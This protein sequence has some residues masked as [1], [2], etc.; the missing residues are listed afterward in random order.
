MLFEA[1]KS[2]AAGLPASTGLRSRDGF[3]SY[4]DTVED[5]EQAAAALLARGV[6]PGDRVALLLPNS[7]A[8]FIATHALFAIG[9][10]AV[11]LSA[12]ANARELAWAADACTIAAIVL[13]PGAEAAADGIDSTG[14]L[15]RILATGDDLFARHA[16]STLPQVSGDAHAV[17]LFSS[18]STGR[19]KV[20]PHTH[21]EMHANG[22]ATAAGLGYTPGDVVL[23]ALPGYH[24]FGFMSAH[25]EAVA[26]GATTL[27]WS[28]PQP[29]VMSRE[30]LLA[31][32]AAEG[33]TVL[34]GV[35][36]LFDA[37][38]GTTS[39]AAPGVL[40]L[41][42]SGGVAL[43]RPSFERFRDRF[44]ILIRQA[45]GSTEAGHMSF[46]RSDDAGTSWNSVGRPVGEVEIRV[47]PHEDAPAGTGELFVRSPSLTRG[48]LG[49]DASA[50][51][52][53]VDGG[54]LT[55]DLGRVD[56]EGKVFITG[57][58]KLIIEVAGQKVDPIEI[59]DILAAHPAVEEAV[60]VGAASTR[61][62]QRLKAVV[63][64]RGEVT[65]RELL[66]HCQQR[67]SAHKIPEIVEFRDAIP[68]SGAGKVLRGK[69]LD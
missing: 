59:E 36:L 25:F 35:P 9:A 57:R 11:P 44:G 12:Q 18:G 50:A 34:P 1:F 69:L 46:N 48:Y 39:G 41:C 30:R 2:R 31:T 16:P 19:P 58:A 56:A 67:L 62:E 21:A 4:Q 61:G 53:F 28:D 60:V 26:G 63:V 32:L 49:A 22:I 29:L 54:Y 20:V 27:F 7:P 13:V 37:L 68:R 64:R 55:G 17:F 42:Y 8:L 51:A 10:V 24:G 15:P 23:N 45:Y 65:D 33:V 40:R 5:I 66:Q 43:R 47:V 52:A 3:R 38:A 14:A 6:E